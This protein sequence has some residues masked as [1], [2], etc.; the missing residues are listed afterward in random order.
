MRIVKKELKNRKIE[1]ELLVI[2]GFIK[3]N[4]VYEFQASLVDEQFTIVVTYANKEMITKVIDMNTNE[5]YVLVDIS[6]ASGEFLGVIRETYEERI[7]DIIKNC[8]VEDIFKNEVTKEVIRYIETTYNGE[9]EFLWKKTPNNA[10]FRHKENK[11]WY[12]ALLTVK[13]NKLG[14]NNDE[15]VEII[16]LK[17]TPEEIEK[18][19]DNELYYC[20]Y[21]MNKK[22]WF[23]IVLD[24]SVPLETIYKFIDISYH[25]NQK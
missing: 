6:R 24:G 17:N 14:I 3:H 21:H 15:L 10:I 11:K 22:H 5:E 4:D 8:T 1:E 18:I 16:D 7:N 23:T 2:Y 9:L 20:G 19:V 25:L 12:A 13:A